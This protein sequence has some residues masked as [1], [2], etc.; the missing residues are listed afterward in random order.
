M[1]PLLHVAR[2]HKTVGVT[3][4]GH[5]SLTSPRAPERDAQETEGLGPTMQKTRSSFLVPRGHRSSCPGPPVPPGPPP[6]GRAGPAPG[7]QGSSRRSEPRLLFPQVVP[8]HAGLCHSLAAGR[9]GRAIVRA[10]P[11][12]P[13]P[14]RSPLGP[15]LRMYV[16]LLPPRS[17]RGQPGSW[18]HPPADL[19]CGQ[20]TAPPT[21]FQPLLPLKFCKQ[22]G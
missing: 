4:G 5:Q 21:A 7:S 8:Q 13:G 16:Q 17:P 12:H 1:R 10:G 19:S 14:S 3:S 15:P 9:G 18:P 11:V 2:Q 22:C 6:R 20:G